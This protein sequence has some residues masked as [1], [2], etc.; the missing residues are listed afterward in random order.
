M[1]DNYFEKI[2]QEYREQT[3]QQAKMEAGGENVMGK[4]EVVAVRKNDDGDIIAF[5]TN[6]GRELDYIT[7]LDEAKAGK[8]AHIDVFHKYGR[9]IIR[10]E[11]DGIEENNL[12]NLPSF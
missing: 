4:E 8:I 9:D 7:A 2:Y 3:M 5:K 6:T 11:P 12:D 1:E 10:S